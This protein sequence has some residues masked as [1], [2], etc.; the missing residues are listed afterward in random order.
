MSRSRTDIKDELMD[1]AREQ[2]L[3]QVYGMIDT[4]E[5]NVYRGF[6]ICRARTLDGEV[7]VYGEKFILIM[8]MRGGTEKCDSVQEAKDFLKTL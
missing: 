1:F 7:R 3:D 4:D 6:T 2:G 5:G 8:T